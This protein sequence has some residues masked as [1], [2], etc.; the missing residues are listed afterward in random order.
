[1]SAADKR[2]VVALSGGVDSSV[3]AALL[4]REGYDVIGMMMRLWSD[5]ALGGAEHN[6]CCTPDQMR[7]A[8]R[9]ADTL[10]IPFYALDTKD[11]F[12]DI[13]VQYFIDQHRDGYTPNPCLECNRHIRFEWLLRHAMALDADFLATGHYARIAKR[14]EGGYLLKKGLDPAK[15]Q[16]YVLSVMGQ[17]QLARTL[18]PV[19]EYPKAEVRRIACELGLDIANRKDSQDLCFL[20][21]NDYRDFLGAHAP[22]LM[23]RG[24]IV[25]S[26]G[27]VLGEHRGLSNYTIGQRKGL[28]V[29][30]NEP[31]YVLAMNAI[32]NALVVG[33]RGELG[34]DRLVAERFNWVGGA[35]PAV[36]FRAEV[37]IRYRS[38]AQMALIKPMGD[39][40][41]LIEFNLPQQAVTPGQ[42]AVVYQ[43]DVCL[44]GGLIA[45]FADEEDDLKSSD[46][47]IQFIA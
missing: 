25:S 39:D 36:E 4:A 43:G 23:T 27:E 34:R 46:Q 9:V 37:K 42:A 35:P 38:Q 30:S 29:S 33:T 14:P 28:G 7:I 2:V 12:R 13:V 41:A 1:M 17:E 19:G 22:D 11:V 24:P 8:R 32:K 10:G 20:G 45:Q 15:D 26:E 47:M 5:E 31:L 3:A 18:F 40:C 6:R 16:S 21:N 44:G